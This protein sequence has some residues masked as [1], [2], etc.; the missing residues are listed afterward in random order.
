MVGQLLKD[1]IGT[2]KVLTDEESDSVIKWFHDHEDLH[3]EGMVYASTEDGKVSEVQT[4][5]D[6]KKTT[7]AYPAPDDPISHLL[8]YAIMNAYQAYK[9]DPEHLYPLGQ[10]LVLQDL[11]VRRYH[12]GDGYFKKHAD[13]SHGPTSTRQYGVLIYLNDVEEGGETN[14]DEIFCKIKPEKGKLLIFPC[15]FLYNHC[16]EVPISGDKYAVTCFI[17]YPLWLPD[18]MPKSL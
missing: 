14:F 5:G 18:E 1:H 17:C 10:P 6:R 12:K 3:M 7:Q 16:G 13:Q 11:S 8:S 2:Y 4:V 9:D 15:N